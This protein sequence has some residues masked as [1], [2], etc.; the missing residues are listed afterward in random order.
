M[1]AAA[2]EPEGAV[3]DAEWDSIVAIFRNMT[4]AVDKV[5]PRPTKQQAKTLPDD[6]DIAD[7]ESRLSDLSYATTDEEKVVGLKSITLWLAQWTF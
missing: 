4:D 5:R 2:E 3:P 6:E 7:L 1:S